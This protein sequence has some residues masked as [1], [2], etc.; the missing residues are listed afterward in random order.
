MARR[1]GVAIGGGRKQ[2]GAEGKAES[3]TGAHIG[4]TRVRH[5]WAIAVAATSTSC[6][7]LEVQCQGPAAPRLPNL[8]LYLGETDGRQSGVRP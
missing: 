6:F 5:H 7:S 1:L 2:A 4:H 3:C 8:C